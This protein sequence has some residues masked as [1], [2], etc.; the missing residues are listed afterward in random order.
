MALTLSCAVRLD[1]DRPGVLGPIRVS[2]TIVNDADQSVDVVNPDAG[3]PPP[4][5]QWPASGEAYRLAVL[6]G[7]GLFSLAVER[8]GHPVPSKGLAP[9]VTPILA[10]R[11]LQ[12]NASLS[13][14]F[15]LS[16]FFALDK[17]GL[18]T[19]TITYHDQ[20]VRAEGYATFRVTSGDH[21]SSSSAA[22]A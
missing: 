13:L 2:V 4:G 22:D 18:Y 7:Q 1:T 9:W 6:I 8:D 11:A 3:S 20:D 15:D 14:Q 17:P 16:E 12:P 19:V 21:A 10:R 5:L